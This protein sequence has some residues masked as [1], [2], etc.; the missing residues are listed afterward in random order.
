MTA[1]VHKYS[2]F[3]FCKIEQ[4]SPII[5]HTKTPSTFP[6]VYEFSNGGRR[7]RQETVSLFPKI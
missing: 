3:I 4:D 1:N 7:D 5:T 2:F 6:I